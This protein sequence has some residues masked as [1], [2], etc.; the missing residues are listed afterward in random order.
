MTSHVTLQKHV[1]LSHYVVA[2]ILKSL[3][4]GFVFEFSIHFTRKV[5]ALKTFVCQLLL[6]AEQFFLV[7]FLKST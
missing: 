3:R 5:F 2:A 6:V 4:L 1:R 7:L